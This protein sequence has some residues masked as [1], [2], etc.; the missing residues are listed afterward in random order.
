[1]SA[2]AAAGTVPAF[3]EEISSV[4]SQ[5][6][7]SE[8]TTKQLCAWCVAVRVGSALDEDAAHRCMAGVTD[9]FA[10]AAFCKVIVKKRGADKIGIG[11]LF[12]YLNEDKEL[13]ADT[14]IVASS[15]C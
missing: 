14:Y 9:C 8:L 15:V 6:R 12:K 7:V 13:L 11:V 2:P 10:S 3:D 5:R 4:L 1:M